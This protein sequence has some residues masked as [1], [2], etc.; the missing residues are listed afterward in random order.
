MTSAIIS[1]IVSVILLAITGSAEGDQV[2]A[3]PAIIGSILLALSIFVFVKI[4]KT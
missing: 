3:V 2:F 4:K 1:I